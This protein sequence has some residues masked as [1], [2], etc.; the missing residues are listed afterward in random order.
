MLFMMVIYLECDENF[1]GI[2]CKEQCNQNCDG[3][4]Q[5]TGA[6]D[7]GCKPGWKGMACKEGKISYGVLH[8]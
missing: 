6:C 2:N 3:C 7:T 4:N 8:R 1:F 5:R